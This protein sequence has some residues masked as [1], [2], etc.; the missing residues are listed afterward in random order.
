MQKEKREDRFLGTVVTATWGQF[1]FDTDG[2]KEN[3]SCI[4]TKIALEVR[5]T[6]VNLNKADKRNYKNQYEN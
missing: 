6:I 5:R 1:E 4:L 3:V 2:K